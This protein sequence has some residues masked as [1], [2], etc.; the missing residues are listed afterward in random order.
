MT[1]SAKK[2]NFFYHFLFLS[3]YFVCSPPPFVHLLFWFFLCNF[4][5]GL[6]L[7]LRV[8]LSLLLVSTVVFLSLL[9]HPSSSCAISSIVF[10]FFSVFFF[11]YMCLSLYQYFSLYYALSFLIFPFIFLCFFRFSI[12][13][14]VYLLLLYFVASSCTGLFSLSS[15]VSFSPNKFIRNKL[16]IAKKYYHRS[17]Y[18]SQ[19]VSC[20]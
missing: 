4:F 15:L 20:W 3:A 16:W 14:T 12:Y 8:C 11:F 17:Q 10:A 7:F 18:P 5:F 6:S 1:E 2:Y 13:T 19:G 9:F